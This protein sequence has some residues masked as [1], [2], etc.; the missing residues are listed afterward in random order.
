[1]K[2]FLVLALTM[3]AVPATA[4]TVET[5]R[6]D[7]DKFPAVKRKSRPLDAS[8][9]VDWAERILASGKCQLPGQRP[10]KF[11]I[12]VPYVAL[13]EPNGTVKRIIVAET[14]CPELETLV[15]STVV[16]W[17]KRGDFK[18]TGHTQ[19]LWFVDRIKF[20]RE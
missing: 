6:T 2:R 5:G 16:D 4:Q 7:W 14:G 20:A 15:G 13:V 10:T 3:V 17:V 18:P 1:M 19:P 9:L 8:L 12:D 11:D